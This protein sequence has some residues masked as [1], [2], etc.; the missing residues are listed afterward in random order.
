MKTPEKQRKGKKQLS[1][2]GY[3]PR[4]EDST[5]LLEKILETSRGTKKKAEKAKENVDREH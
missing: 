2:Y 3:P 5:L 4:K 1:W